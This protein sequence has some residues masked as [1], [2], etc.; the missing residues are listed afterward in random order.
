MSNGNNEKSS[1]CPS[2]IRYKSVENC[3]ETLEPDFVYPDLPSRCRWDR[4]KRNESS[5]HSIR[6]L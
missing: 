1:T 6:P 4:S 5:P 3:P 2:H